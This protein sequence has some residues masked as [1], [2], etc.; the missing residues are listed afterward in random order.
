MRRTILPLLYVGNFQ[1][2]KRS[3]RDI[4]PIIAVHKTASRFGA[5]NPERPVLLG[6]RMDESSL[7]RSLAAR[8]PARPR[9]SWRAMPPG[10]CE[11]PRPPGTPGKGWLRAGPHHGRHPESTDVA[12]WTGRLVST[13]LGWTLTSEPA[14]QPRPPGSLGRGLAQGGYRVTPVSAAQYFS[15]WSWILRSRAAGCAVRGFR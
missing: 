12:L 8:A 3:R 4:S 1:R 5:S 13:D 9:T 11:Q 15:S 10:C 14:H 6:S 2:L 7:L